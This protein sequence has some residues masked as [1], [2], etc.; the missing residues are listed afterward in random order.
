MFIFHHKPLLSDCQGIV[1]GWYKT[2]LSNS[3]HDLNAN[4]FLVAL[5]TK[6]NKLGKKP[7]YQE[8]YLRG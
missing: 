1:G 2:G 5:Y 6:K 3:K 8:L 7:V 4:K